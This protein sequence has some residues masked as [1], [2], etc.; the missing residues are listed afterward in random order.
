MEMFLQFRQRSQLLPQVNKIFL[1]TKI[2][3]ERE[4]TALDK[5]ILNSI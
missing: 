3:P 2:W 1:V 4:V 5:I